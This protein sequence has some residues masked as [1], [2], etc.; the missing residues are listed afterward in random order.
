[1][2]KKLLMRLTTADISLEGLL[3]GQLRFLN[4]YYDVV[5]VAS[6]TGSL[7]FVA[8]REGIRVVDVPMHRQISP[9]A[10]LRSL[11]DLYRL[12]RREHPWC[13]HANTPKGSLLAMAAAW[14]AQIG[15][16]S[17]RERV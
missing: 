12:F 8:K 10:D 14:A 11:R 13:V 2:N 17:C 1:M 3:R 7:D 9:V 16:A 5:G 6:D 4:Q 15:R